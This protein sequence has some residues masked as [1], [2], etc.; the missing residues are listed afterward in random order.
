MNWVQI[1]PKNV[2]PNVIYMAESNEPERHT[3]AISGIEGYWWGSYNGDRHFDLGWAPT[4]EL[5]KKRAQ[6]IE[7]YLNR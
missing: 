3:F 7:E 5:A 6:D 4:L 1:G 2:G